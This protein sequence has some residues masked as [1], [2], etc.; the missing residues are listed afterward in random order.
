MVRTSVVM[1]VRSP[2]M[3]G[4]RARAAPDRRETASLPLGPITPDR[5]ERRDKGSHDG[6]DVVRDRIRATAH[7]RASRRLDELRVAML[8]AADEGATQAQTR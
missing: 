7:A 6:P 1:V 8:A 3:E 5:A 2:S 4:C